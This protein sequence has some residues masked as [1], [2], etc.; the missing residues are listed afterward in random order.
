MDAQQLDAYFARI[1]LARPDDVDAA[2]LRRIQQAHLAHIPFEN[3]D[4]LAGHLPLSFGEDALYDKLVVRRRGGICY[5]Q[6]LLFAAVLRAL[7]CTVA[8]KGGNIYDDGNPFDHIFLQVGLDDGSFWLCDVGFAYLFDGP[9]DMDSDAVQRPRSESYRIVDCSEAGQ[10]WRAVLHLLVD[11]EAKTMFRF[12]PAEYEPTDYRER[13]DFFCTDAGSRFVK[14]PL[15]AIDA[16]E[17]R[18][19]LSMERYSW[20]DDGAVHAREVD[21]C[22]VADLLQRVFGLR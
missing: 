2:A 16:G 21:A 20:V 13:C 11:G 19:V 7:G 10:G 3:L 4:I 1:G 8:L 15:V 12:G 18:G 17:G 6:N 14:G 9:L 22:E 5:E